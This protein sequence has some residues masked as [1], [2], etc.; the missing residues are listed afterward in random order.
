M[1]R[2]E[3]QTALEEINNGQR[4]SQ[5]SMLTQFQRDAVQ[6]DS[7]EEGILEAIFGQIIT[8]PMPTPEIL[9]QLNKMTF[10]KN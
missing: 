8:M 5:Q 7:D 3:A 2:Q 9:S 1:R 10:K 6:P 4:L